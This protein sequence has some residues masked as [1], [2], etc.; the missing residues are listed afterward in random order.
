MGEGETARLR[1]GETERMGEWENERRV[2][3]GRDWQN[4]S[5]LPSMIANI[6]L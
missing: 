4:P 2:A 3:K 1:E 6:K 5:L